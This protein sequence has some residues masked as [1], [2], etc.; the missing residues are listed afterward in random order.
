MNGAVEIAVAE[1]LTTFLLVFEGLLSR[2]EV[3]IDGIA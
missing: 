2:S 1:K 3:G